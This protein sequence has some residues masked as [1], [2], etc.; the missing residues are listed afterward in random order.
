M[1]FMDY[2]FKSLVLN[3]K[4]ANKHKS[5]LVFSLSRLFF[6]SHILFRH[7]SQEIPKRQMRR[8]LSV[9]LPRI[10]DFY[11]SCVSR[12]FATFCEQAFRLIG[13]SL[14]GR[15]PALPPYEIKR[16]FHLPSREI[17]IADTLHKHAPLMHARYYTNERIDRLRTNLSIAIFR[18]M[19]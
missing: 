2:G 9:L 4:N 6:I 14:A 5:L 8:L 1:A 11:V 17:S 15:T 16:S 10:Y 19:Y 3:L 7:F 18:W 12:C 13:T